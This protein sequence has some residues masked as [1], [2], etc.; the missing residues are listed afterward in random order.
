[1]H[2]EQSIKL[3]EVA[4]QRFSTE[5]RSAMNVPEYE[6]E[7]NKSE[8]YSCSELS[9]LT[10]LKNR[11]PFSNDRDGNI[12]SLRRN[13]PSIYS[14]LFKSQLSSMG[15]VLESVRWLSIIWSLFQTVFT[16][17][18][19]SHAVSATYCAVEKEQMILNNFLYVAKNRSNTDDKP[20]TISMS[21]YGELKTKDT[22]ARK[23]T[24]KLRGTIALWK[25]IFNFRK[26]IDKHNNTN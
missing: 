20:M 5:F 10:D 26:D 3:V 1:M 19:L 23:V 8:E 15:K 11:G 14:P 16:S 7:E 24:Q 9:F 25:N 4:L 22:T 21:T 13:F 2:W 6:I 18:K 12:S 17:K